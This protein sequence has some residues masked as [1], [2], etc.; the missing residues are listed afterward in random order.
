LLYL[1]SNIFPFGL[2]RRGRRYLFLL[3]GDLFLLLVSYYFLSVAVLSMSSRFPED[4]R[5]AAGVVPVLRVQSYGLF[6]TRPNFLRTF[7]DLFLN[8]NRNRLPDT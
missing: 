3:D 1:F 7:F 6:L 4:P 2:T 5:P 8:Q